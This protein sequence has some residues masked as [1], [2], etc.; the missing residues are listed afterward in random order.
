MSVHSI[1]PP[2]LSRRGIYSRRSACRGYIWPTLRVAQ[3]GAVSKS[4]A[5]R[6][7][8]HIC[9][10]QFV[11]EQTQ[12]AVRR[13]AALQPFYQEAAALDQIA[14]GN[15][16]AVGASVDFLIDYLDALSDAGAFQGGHH[17][18]GGAHGARHANSVRSR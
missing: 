18:T 13:Q 5:G 17:R 1:K 11:E 7:V 4:P 9:Y 16:E 3:I 8:R 14:R 2:D 12:I 6:R 15:A 10:G